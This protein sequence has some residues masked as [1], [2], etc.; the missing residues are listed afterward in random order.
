[1]RMWSKMRPGFSE[2]KLISPWLEAEGSI[3]SARP[4][5]KFALHDVLRAVTLAL[6]REAGEGKIASSIQIADNLLRL[7]ILS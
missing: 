7:I 1:M 6:S 2:P 3:S 4:T 5:R